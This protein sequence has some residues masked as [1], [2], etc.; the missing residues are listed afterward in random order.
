MNTGRMLLKRTKIR[1]RAVGKG[2]GSYDL[3]GF[4]ILNLV[5]LRHRSHES[6]LVCKGPYDTQRKL[7]PFAKH[8]S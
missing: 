1:N 3:I 7:V 2:P 5:N 6:F 8:G 4:S